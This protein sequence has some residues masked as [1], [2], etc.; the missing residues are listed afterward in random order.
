V[1]DSVLF[2]FELSPPDEILHADTP[3]NETANKKPTINFLPCFTIPTLLLIIC[4]GLMLPI[5]ISFQMNNNKSICQKLKRC[6]E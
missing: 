5:N 2:L 3:T 6:E 1:A 4:K